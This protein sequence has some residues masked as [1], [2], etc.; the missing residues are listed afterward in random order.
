ML[1]KKK[2]IDFE[3]ELLRTLLFF[4]N[5]FKRGTLFFRDLFYTKYFCGDDKIRTIPRYDFN[6]K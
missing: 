5:L 2:L 4:M 1:F 3:V 6:G